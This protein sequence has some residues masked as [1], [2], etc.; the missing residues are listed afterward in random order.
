MKLVVKCIL[1]VVFAIG[2]VQ[3]FKVIRSPEAK[4][5][6]FIEKGVVLAGQEHGGI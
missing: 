6:S 5:A 3:I 4:N 2:A 1:V